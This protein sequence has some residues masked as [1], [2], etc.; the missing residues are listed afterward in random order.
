[1]NA[2]YKSLYFEI[3]RIS[4]IRHYLSLDVNVT[5][6]VSLIFSKVDY[7]DAVLSGL[8]LDQLYKLQKV[9]NYVAEVIFKTNKITVP[10]LF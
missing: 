9:Q 6:M 3:R 2:L 5:L 1:M 7:G 10:S 8:S 4:Q